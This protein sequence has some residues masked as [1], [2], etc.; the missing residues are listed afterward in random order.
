M[1]L[2][3]CKENG[4][5]SISGV[6]YNSKI[7]DSIPNSAFIDSVEIGMQKFSAIKKELFAKKNL[8]PLEVL[9]KSDSLIKLYSED[10]KKTKFSYNINK[11]KDLHFLKGEIFYETN[12]FHNALKEFSFDTIQSYTIARAATYIKLNQFEKALENIKTQQNL[13]DKWY[14]GNYYEIVGK[15][16]SAKI[17]YQKLSSQYPIYDVEKNSTLRLKELNR[18]KPKLLKELQIPK[19]E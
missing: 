16:D 11:I 19:R 14:L 3:S 6:N 2:T 5:K 15:I 10:Y 9:K 4:E 18:K 1:A 17:Q 7:V 12:D 13:E 8:K